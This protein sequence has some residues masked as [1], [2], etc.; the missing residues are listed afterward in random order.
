VLEK[1]ADGGMSSVHKARHLPTGAVVAVKILA[2]EVAAN[3]VLR[4]RLHREFRAAS[5]LRHPNLVRALD[6]GCEG[7]TTYL[8]M[9]YVD[10][11]DL[12]QRVERAGPLAEGE[13]V[14]IV[15]QVAQALAYAHARGIIHRDV[16]PDNVLVTADGVAKLADLGLAKDLEAG[17][18]LT[19]TRRGL[20]TP[21]FIAPEQFSDARHADVRCDI[22][23][24]GATLYT[25]VT[26]E[27]PFPA[28]GVAG[29]LR[30]KLNDELVAPG[31]LA[32]SLSE[33][34]DWAVRRAMRA[35]PA[36]RHASCQ[37][38]ANA[39]TGGEGSGP[40]SAGPL[41]ARGGRRGRPSRPPAEERRARVRYSCR[42]ET[43]CTRN[44]SIHPEKAAQ[45][46]SWEAT[47]L[48]LSA[49]GIGLLLNR[50]FEPGTNLVLDLR[51]PGQ[52]FAREVEL[53]VTRVKSAAGGAWFHGCAFAEPL[54]QEELR[55]LL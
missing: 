38:F 16:K 47:V 43:G 5:A 19:R 6:G 44:T 35:N 8:V 14:R 52:G 50:R 55:K 30:K 17:G 45:H 7:E 11:E 2:P 39:L 53:C 37:E 18:D 40:S 20:G 46:D 15:V 29:V 48:D 25:A 13:A 54:S 24:L 12:W 3:R 10:G 34:V 51:G 32:P 4:E 1:I 22:Y 49:V 41:A 26:G 36:E 27:L 28:R 33:R 23:S 9:E 21:N 42:L 31:K